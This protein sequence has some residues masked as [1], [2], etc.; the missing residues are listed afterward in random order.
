MNRLIALPMK[1][2]VL[3]NQILLFLILFDKCQ[4]K[5]IFL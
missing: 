3:K 2:I 4:E 5:T 1:H